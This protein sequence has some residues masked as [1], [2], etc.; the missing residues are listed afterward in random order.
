VGEE[1][2]SNETQR[3]PPCELLN[4]G[5]G[6]RVRPEASSQSAA[7]RQRE[8]LPETKVLVGS[9]RNAHKMISTTGHFK[10]YKYL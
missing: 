8:S 1:S 3:L 5:L 10:T 4:K 7:K 2:L 6:L 9:Q